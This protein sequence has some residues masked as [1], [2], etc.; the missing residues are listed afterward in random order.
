MP[1]QRRRIYSFGAGKTVDNFQRITTDPQHAE[2]FHAAGMRIRRQHL[3]GAQGRNPLF[4]D[5]NTALLAEPLATDGD[6]D[7]V[8]HGRPA[9]KTAIEGFRQPQQGF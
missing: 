9:D 2:R 3:Y 6:T 5:V 4:G 1:F 8:G 7:K